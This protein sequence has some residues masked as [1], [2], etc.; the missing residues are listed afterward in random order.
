MSGMALA[1]GFT[2][3]Y[4]TDVRLNNPLNLFI[5]WTTYGAWFPGDRR[6]WRKWKAGEQVPQPLLADWCRDRMN[7]P[8][9]TLNRAHRVTVIKTCHRHAKIRGWVVH[10][11]DARSNHVHLVVTAAAEPKKVRDQFKANATRALREMANPTTNMKIWTRG[12]DVEVVEGDEQLDQ[13]VFYVNDAQD[14]MGQVK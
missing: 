4:F 9:V 5:T 14:R 3:S 8:P 7:E 2:Q 10:A 11:I 6:G 12:G 13:V 1:T